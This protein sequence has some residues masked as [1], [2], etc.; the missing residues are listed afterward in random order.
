MRLPFIRLSEPL[1]VKVY[2]SFLEKDL[3]NAPPFRVF[4]MES[5]PLSRPTRTRFF[6][7]QAL[8][9]WLDEV[10]LKMIVFNIAFTGR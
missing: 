5:Y 7:L 3:H 9:T 6:N 4:F 1:G 8:L 2:L 10:P